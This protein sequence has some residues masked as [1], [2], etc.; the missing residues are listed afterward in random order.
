MRSLSP[1]FKDDRGTTWHEGADRRRASGP[2]LGLLEFQEY[3]TF[4]CQVPSGA[5]ILLYPDGIPAAV[6][7]ADE[8][9][10]DPRLDA[11]LLDHAAAPAQSLVTRLHAVVQD[12]SKGVPPG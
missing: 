3:R 11:Y 6:N 12:F 10:G 8:F 9:F 5:A 7:G 1:M 4:H 2:L